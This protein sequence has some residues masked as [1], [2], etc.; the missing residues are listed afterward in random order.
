MW[1]G[2]ALERARVSPPKPQPMS[3]TLGWIFTV[4]DEEDRKEE[5]DGVS[6]SVCVSVSACCCFVIVNNGCSG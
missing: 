6:S 4:V 2:N 5:D 3:R 1:V